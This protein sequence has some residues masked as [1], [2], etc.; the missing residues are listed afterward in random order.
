MGFF[1][2]LWGPSDSGEQE[3]ESNEKSGGSGRTDHE[4]SSIHYTD[5][6]DSGDR[7]SWNEKGSDV[8]DQ[9]STPGDNKGS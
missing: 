7:A 9:H 4:S 2:H 6:S 5:W 3:S 1:D 8:S